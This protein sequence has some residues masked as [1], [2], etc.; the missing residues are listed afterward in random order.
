MNVQ[1]KTK[2]LDY[3]SRLD[4]LINTHRVVKEALANRGPDFSD[5]N[6]DLLGTQFIEYD[7]GE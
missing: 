6:P 5:R 7:E 3:N 4:V 1:V 2:L